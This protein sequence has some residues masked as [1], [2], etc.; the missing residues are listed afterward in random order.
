MDKIVSSTNT[1]LTKIL[2]VFKKVC[3]SIIYEISKLSAYYAI[4]ITTLL[5]NVKSKEKP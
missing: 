1:L 2:K 5:G 4:S 3:K